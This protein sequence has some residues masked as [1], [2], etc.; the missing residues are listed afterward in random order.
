MDFLLFITGFIRVGIPLCIKII[1][2]KEELTFFKDGAKKLL[3]K[4]II[5]ILIWIPIIALI[6]FFCFKPEIPFGKGF[7]TGLIIYTIPTILNSG[8]NQTNLQEFEHS[9]KCNS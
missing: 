5:S 3:K 2:N 4:Y 1:N 6:I 8:K 7:I 9:L